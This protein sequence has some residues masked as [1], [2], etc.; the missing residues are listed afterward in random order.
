MEHIKRSQKK[1]YWCLIYVKILIKF[2]YYKT[3]NPA[4]PLCKM[5]LNKLLFSTWSKKIL[6][7][8]DNNLFNMITY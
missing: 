4:Y 7:K 2:T 1:Y 6:N 8:A 3:L 5:K